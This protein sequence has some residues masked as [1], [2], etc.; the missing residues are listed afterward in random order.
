M[1]YLGREGAL[2]LESKEDCGLE[3]KE[4]KEDCGGQKVPKVL[5]Q[6]TSHLLIRLVYV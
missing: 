6:N 3:S 2:S 4:S 1:V 5:L